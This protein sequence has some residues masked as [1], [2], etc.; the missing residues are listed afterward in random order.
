MSLVLHS[1]WPQVPVLTNIPQPPQPAPEAATVSVSALDK[2]TRLNKEALYRLEWQFSGTRQRGVYIYYPIIK[3]MVGS[4]AAFDSHEFALAVASWQRENGFT[5]TGILDAACWE[6]MVEILQGSRLKS[7]EIPPQNELVVVP[8]AEFFDPT[9][10]DELRK[11]HARAYEAYKRMISAALADPK[12]AA[13]MADG[14]N[15]EA[16]NYFKI[17]SSW[18]SREYQEKLRKQQRGGLGRIALAKNSPHFTGRALDIYVGGL[19]VSTDNGNRIKQINTPAYQWLVRN[20]ERF[21]FRP[22]FFEPWHWE[23]VGDLTDLTPPQDQ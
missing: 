13:A 4:P 23:Y 17:I 8:T 19:P 2:A 1:V 15:K 12:V 7:R 11:V 5:T 10:P 6:R 22:Y 18:R 20:A 9:R 16:R 14:N 3:Q 21:G